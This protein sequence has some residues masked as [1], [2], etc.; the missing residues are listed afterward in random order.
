[1]EAAAWVAE[2]R[3]T[4]GHILVA[5]EKEVP[6]KIDA[7]RKAIEEFPGTANEMLEMISCTLA[8]RELTIPI[9]IML[10][11]TKRSELPRWTDVA[12]RWLLDGIDVCAAENVPREMKNVVNMTLKKSPSGDREEP[13]FIGQLLAR[14]RREL[15]GVLTQALCEIMHA[16]VSSE[17]FEVARRTRE[18]C[19]PISCCGR[20][21]SE[22]EYLGW[23]YDNA[24]C[25]LRLD[26]SAA[27]QAANVAIC[28][29]QDT[30]N[31]E[32]N[33]GIIGRA[34]HLYVVLKLIDFGGAISSTVPAAVGQ[35]FPQGIPAHLK[36]Y[37]NSMMTTGSG[38]E[39]SMAVTARREIMNDGE[40]RRVKDVIGKLVLMSMNGEERTVLGEADMRT[41]ES[42]GLRELVENRLI[43]LI[44]NKKTLAKLKQISAIYSR[45]PLER[46]LNSL[47]LPSTQQ[48]RDEFL[49][50]VDLFNSCENL[51]G[52]YSLQ[53]EDGLGVFAKRSSA[54]VDI[55]QTLYIDYPSLLGAAEPHIA[56]LLR[57]K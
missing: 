21:V 45:I 54:G 17:A 25:L 24:R 28:C 49:I 47:G 31:N 51:C 33:T 9:A 44:A 12:Q 10:D 34:L 35:L 7:L 43:P 1:M 14:Y 23:W 16:S 52:A 40:R 37:V 56:K 22:M 27:I 6:G 11:L 5:R 30:L 15:P 50:L 8:E 32:E 20:G 2:L 38:R 57:T 26:I 39:A 36:K 41:L 29:V 48:G 42:E 18:S 53:I 4:T 13:A 3:E 46:L 19:S 55:G